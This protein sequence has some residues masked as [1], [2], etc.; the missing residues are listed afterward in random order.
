LKNH[1]I[2]TIE[3]SFAAMWAKL[4]TLQGDIAEKGIEIIWKTQGG[5]SC[6]VF[7]SSNI[8]HMSGDMRQDLELAV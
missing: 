3:R 8:G 4:N 1:Q 7:K 2:L 6:K 5:Q